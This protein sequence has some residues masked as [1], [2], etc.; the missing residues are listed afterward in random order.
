M[1]GKVVEEIAGD[2]YTRQVIGEKP[3]PRTVLGENHQLCIEECSGRRIEA[4]GESLT[5]PD[6]IGEFSIP[7]TEIEYCHV[8][9]R[10]R[11][12]SELLSKG[13]EISG[14]R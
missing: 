10:W 2:N 11:A 4:H 9:W 1:S 6:L 5:G 7:T 14:R 13:V 12:I 3:A 8:G